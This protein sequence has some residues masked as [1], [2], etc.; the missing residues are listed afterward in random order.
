MID[1][2]KIRELKV[3]PSIIE[4]AEFLVQQKGENEFPDYRKLDLMKI[5]RMVS[6]LW[7]MDFRSVSENGLLVHF[8]GTKVDEQYGFNIMGK[9]FDECY[10]GDYKEQLIEEYFTPVYASKKIGFTRRKDF[11]QDSTWRTHRVIE[12]ML[13]PCS[14]DGEVINFG[15]GVTN[16]M[17]INRDEDVKTVFTA[18]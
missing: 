8:S 1:L 5:P 17:T 13:F 12:T 6:H 15:A 18:I 3:G 11:Y 10:T 16:F 4:F 9:T 14:S 7:V 2:E